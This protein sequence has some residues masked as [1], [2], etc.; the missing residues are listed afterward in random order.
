MTRIADRKTKLQ[1]ETSAVYRGRPLVVELTPHYVLVRE[2]GTRQGLSVPWLAVHELGLK[3]QA[4]SVA[5]E[6]PVRRS[7]RKT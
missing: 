5:R 7:S 6:I 4:R 3:L 2:K 1:A